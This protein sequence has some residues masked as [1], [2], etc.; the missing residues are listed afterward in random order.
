MLTV[1]IVQPTNGANAP[2]DNSG[3][4]TVLGTIHPNPK[5]V[6]LDALHAWLSVGGAATQYD[7]VPLTDMTTYQCKFVIPIPISALGKVV[8]ITVHAIPSDDQGP[9]VHTI[10]VIPT[11]TGSK[12]K[13][14][15]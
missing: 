15:K 10:K 8:Y 13:K 3:N 9:G 1:C 12:I 6:P 11:Q 2:I 5:D 14:K 4:I 7:Y